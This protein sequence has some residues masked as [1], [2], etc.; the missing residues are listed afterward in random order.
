M[1]K[2]ICNNKHTQEDVIKRFQSIHKYDYSEFIYSGVFEKSTIICHEIDEKT[3]LEHGRFQK[4][5]NCHYNFNPP[6][7]CPK[8]GYLK[9]LGSH[10]YDNEYIDNKLIEQGR[11]ETIKRIGTLVTMKDKIEWKCLLDDCDHTW[12]AA[13]ETVIGKP[14]SG[15]PKCAGILKITN[16]YVDDMIKNRNII[17]SENVK[18]CA[19]KISWKCTNK[20]KKEKICNNIWEAAPNSIINLKSGCPRCV[21]SQGNKEMVR[22]LENISEKYDVTFKTEETFED[23]KN[24]T[25][26]RKLR[27]DLVSRNFK[28]DILYLFEFD[29]KCHR[30]HNFYMGFCKND[31]SK[32][33]KMLRDCQ[34]RDSIKDQ[35]CK[36]KNIILIRIDKIKN[37]ESIINDLFSKLPSSVFL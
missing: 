15:C 13:P 37:I 35:Y 20:N 7:G 34:Y 19:E 29:G 22:C 6:Q 11:S 31:E 32:A 3:G 25:S 5:Y 18:L 4:D 17:R 23:C 16:E 1:S 33:L 26:N 24:P 27:F 30:D 21:E 28:G 12:F 14:K 36:N 8:C 10:K 9:R 2:R